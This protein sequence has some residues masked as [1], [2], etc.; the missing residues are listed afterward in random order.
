MKIVVFKYG[1]FNV[2]LYLFIY[3]GYFEMAYNLNILQYIIVNLNTLKDTSEYLDTLTIH[4]LK[5]R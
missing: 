3:S 2:Q 1:T 5:M 4:S